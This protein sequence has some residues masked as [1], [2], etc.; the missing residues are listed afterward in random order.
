MF[1]RLFFC[2]ILLLQ[3]AVA[4]RIVPFVHGFDPDDKQAC[5]FQYYVS[6]NTDSFL[7]FEVTIRERGQTLSGEDVLSDV[8]NVFVVMPSQ[9]IIPPH[10]QRSIKVRWIGGKC[11]KERA[12]RVTFEQFKVDLYNG[13]DST[14]K[15]KGASVD[16]LLKI[17]ASLYVAPAEAK[18][19]PVIVS[20]DGVKLV[21]ENRGSRH[22]RIDDGALSIDGKVYYVKDT[23]VILAGAKRRLQIDP[24]PVIKKADDSKPAVNKSNDKVR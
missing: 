17:G 10:T 24:N 8:D 21:V 2:M 4:L 15:K 14:K 9:V 23:G 5:S 22:V 19:Q 6:N 20:N 13:I 16:I 7:A 18:A 12:F 3:S 11:D 1:I